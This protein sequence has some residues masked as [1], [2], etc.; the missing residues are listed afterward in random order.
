MASS[1][2]CARA[3]PFNGCNMCKG[4]DSQNRKA[5]QSPET[6]RKGGMVIIRPTDYKTSHGTGNTLGLPVRNS[7]R[8]G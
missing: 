2:Y 3:V 1:G 5:L 7:S 6:V 8:Y 4:R